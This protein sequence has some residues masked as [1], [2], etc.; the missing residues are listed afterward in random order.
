MREVQISKT[1][2]LLYPELSYKI[3]GLCFE[4]QNTLGRYLTEKSYADFLEGLLKRDNI[5]YNRE[6]Q[7]PESFVGEKGRRNVADFFIDGKIIVELKSKQ[8]I[9][10]EDYFQVKR[11][12]SATGAKLGLL[13][14][15]QQQY[16]RPKR[17]LSS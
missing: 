3:C 8:L 12:L 4:T 7:I 14:N 16:L 2:K 13:V 1:Q 17:I 15:F 6:Y 9:S 11:Y 10:R 5:V